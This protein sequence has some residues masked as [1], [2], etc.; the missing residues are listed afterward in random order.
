MHSRM[1]NYMS[2]IAIYVVCNMLSMLNR[3]YDAEYV[4]QKNAVHDNVKT[5]VH[6]NESVKVVLINKMIRSS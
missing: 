6:Y 3:H 1:P 4:I 5:C 2:L